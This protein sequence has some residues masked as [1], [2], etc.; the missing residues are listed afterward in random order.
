M[1]ALLALLIWSPS[2]GGPQPGDPSAVAGDAR[3]ARCGSVAEIEYAFAIPHTRDYQQYL[4][5][6]PHF[7][8]LDLDPSA[9]VVIYRAGFGFAGSAP[10]PSLSPTVR[11]LC[12]YVGTAG[13]GELN[14]YSNM[15]IAGLRATPGG[16][17]LL[18]APQT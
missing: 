11:N 4:P 10:S 6:M 13:Q 18:P 17:A 9:L 7:E 3:L 1:A 5:A 12:I 15:S 2:I 14:Y 16:P 8:T